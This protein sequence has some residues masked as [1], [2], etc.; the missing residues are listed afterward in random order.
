[1]QR[2]V[3]ERN[4]FIQL[5]RPMTMVSGAGEKERGRAC[6]R[7]CDCHEVQRNVVCVI[8]SGYCRRRSLGAPKSHGI[9]DEKES[10]LT[11]SA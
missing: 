4:R 3:S 2:S 1:M 5:I 8:S 11:L 7:H 6:M 10:P 9:D